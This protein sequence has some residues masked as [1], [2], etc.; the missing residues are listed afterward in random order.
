MTASVALMS[1]FGVG[2]IFAIIGALK[3]ELAKVLNID[4]TKVGSLISTLMFTSMIMVLITGPIVD[5]VGYKPVAIVGFLVAFISIFLLISAK[6]YKMAV[7]SCIVLGVGGMC[8]NTVGNTLMPVIL[9]D[10]QNAPAALNL[11]NTFFGLGAFVTPLIVGLLL[12]KL[13]YKTTGT[14]IAVILL[15]PVIFA[16]ITVLPDVPT[17]FE[18]SKAFGLLASGIVIIAA[19]ALVCYIGL[20]FSMGGWISTYA[21][22]LGFTDKGANITL[23]VFWISLMIARLTT[24]GF[25]VFKPLVTPEIGASII[26][27]LAIISVITIVIMAVAKS[28]T[29]AV[30]GVILTGLAFGPIFPTIVGVTFSKTLEAL[31]GS[32]FGIIFAVGLFGG[33]FMPT[34]IGIIAKGKTIQKSFMVAIAAAVILFIMALIMGRI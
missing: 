5:S 24:A 31:H 16:I 25:G 2:V 18:M 21:S 22:S 15:I 10:G 17:G 12:S 4:D 9:F 29:I 20:E 23:S 13:G 28:K 27:V 32:A 30:I 34:A 33:S 26:A 3:L 11:G 8:L 6:S 19:L 7:F 1:V 14:I